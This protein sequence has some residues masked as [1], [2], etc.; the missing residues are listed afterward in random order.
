MRKDEVRYVDWKSGGG[1]AQWSPWQ[2]CGARAPES[3]LL[4]ACVV[5]CRGIGRSTRRRLF[6][7]ALTHVHARSTWDFAIIPHPS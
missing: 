4:R 1:G 6:R 2:R 5:V 3:T 7:S